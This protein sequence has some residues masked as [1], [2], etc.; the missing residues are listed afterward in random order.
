MRSVWYNFP[1]QNRSQ[2]QKYNCSRTPCVRLLCF[3][4]IKVKGGI[5][6][7]FAPLERW[8]W[9][10]YLKG[11]GCDVGEALWFAAPFIFLFAIVVVVAGTI[12]TQSGIIIRGGVIMQLENLAGWA[13][14]F[15]SIGTI[16]LAIAT[17][18]LALYTIRVANSTKASVENAR[19]QFEFEQRKFIKGQ[20]ED[21]LD[22]LRGLA[23][24]KCVDGRTYRCFTEIDRYGNI[25]CTDVYEYHPQVFPGREVPEESPFYIPPQFL[26]KYGQQWFKGKIWLNREQIR[27]IIFVGNEKQ[28]KLIEKE[29][30]GITNQ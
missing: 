17:M 7:P 26:D 21:T 25:T 12:I 2:V 3:S 15:T 6:R 27:S 4:E 28:T 23:L 30:E 10:D 1:L 13:N 24:I 11:G 19:E 22:E 16:I 14:I 5:I 29:V 8:V 9:G 18:I 20:F